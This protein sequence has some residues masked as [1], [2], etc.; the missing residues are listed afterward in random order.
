MQK[1]YE[2]TGYKTGEFPVTEQLASEIISLPMFP[3]LTEE[4]QIRVTSELQRFV[5]EEKPAL[6]AAR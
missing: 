5:Y 3:Q 1:A 2:Q 6:I 4:Q